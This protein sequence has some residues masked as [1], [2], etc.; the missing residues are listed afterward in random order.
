MRAI[1]EASVRL[2]RALPCPSP[3]RK[4][5]RHVP[6]ETASTQFLVSGSPRRPFLYRTITA[7]AGS[8]CHSTTAK[9]RSNAGTRTPSLRSAGRS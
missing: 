6:G 4:E 3:A 5:T 7:S 9:E 2:S 1:R 8:F